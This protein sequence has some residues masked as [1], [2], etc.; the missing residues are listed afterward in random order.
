MTKLAIKRPVTICMLVI[1][2]LMLGMVSYNS[3]EQAYMP[4]VDLPVAMVMT[5]Y[6]GA[7]PEEV[8]KLVTEPIES[9]LATMTG[10]DTLTS[11]SSSG[12]SM[13]AVTFV[14]GTDLDEA[15]NDMRDKLE[16]VTRQLPDDADD[17]S[18]MKMDMDSSS[19]QI[20]IT[21]DKMD[22]ASLYD[23]VDENLTYEFERIEGV[24]SVSLNGGVDK[25]IQVVIDPEKISQYGLTISSISQALAAENQD[26]SAGELKQGSQDITLRVAGSFDNI[27]DIKNIYLTTTGGN[28]LLLK[29]VATS[30]EEV[31]LDQERISIIN[32]TEGVM[33]ETTLASDAN[34]VD[35]SHDILDRISE[36]EEKYPDL[37]F[38]M[39]SSTSDYIENSLN[40]VVET[41]FQAAIIAVLI[42]LFFLQN[43]KSAAVIGVSIPTSIMATFGVMKLLGMTMNIVSMGGIV[44][45]IG[46]LVDN[47]VVVLENIYNYRARG[48]SAAEASEKG[49]AEVA[50]AVMASTLTTVAVFAPMLFI[51]G[52]MG[53]MLKD[54]A[55]TICV[56]LAAS[57]FVSITFVPTAC[58]VLMTGED[59]ERK[60][61]KKHTVFNT[62]GDAINGVLSRLDFAYSRLIALCLRHRIITIVVVV[63]IFI[64]S[65][66]SSGMLGM[67]LMG[68]SDEGTLSVSARIPDGYGY[69]YSY[70]ILDEIM[71]AV[72]DIPETKTSYAM[73]GGSN[74]RLEINLVSSDDRQRSTDDIADEIKNEIKNIAG[75]EITVSSGSMAM[76]SMG[77]RGFSLKI[78]GEDTDTLRQICDDLI[79]EFETIDG[80]YDL[81]SSMDEAS[82]QTDIVVDRAKAASYGISSSQIASQVYTYNSGTVG[83]TLKVDGTETDIR[84]MYPDERVEYVKDLYSMTVTTNSGT[85][86]P[87]TE[88]AEIKTSDVPT[89]ISRENQ[90]RY[91]TITGSIENT[92]TST[93]TALITEKLNNY[94]FPDNYS[95][96]F[97][98]MQEYMDEAFGQLFIVLVVA[99]ILVFLIM[100][101]QFE[102]LIQP[103]I[104]M[105]SMPIAITGGMLGL[106]VT[107]L[108]ITAYAFMGFIMLVGMVVNNAIVLVDYA[109]QRRL[110]HGMECDEALIDA[111]RSRLR[112]ILMTTL[113]TVFGMVPMALALSE[114]M[115]TQQSMGVVIIFGL[116][117]S[118]LVT[119]IFIPVVYSLVNS[120]TRK[121]KRITAKFSPY[122]GAE[123]DKYSLAL[124]EY[125][126]NQN[127]HHI[128]G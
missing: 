81:E 67:D 90:Q 6:Q 70:E 124:K 75:A 26:S 69:E 19:F 45:G 18:I 44:I 50:M 60:S 27:E 101:S 80:A 100:A 73:V 74:V 127:N 21:S 118:T 57:Y 10:V 4:T 112:P 15:V 59:R 35:L 106:L 16:R 23:Y 110:L 43:W 115:E 126:K 65:L 99:I 98:G 25:E 7:G 52:T 28:G 97:G 83:T 48:F 3:L 22:I 71:N 78:I 37:H 20:G 68:Q 96:D 113:T 11:R 85:E 40:N 108:S 39:L 56:A 104:V 24:A 63:A 95:Y 46:M 12:S 91:V 89:T 41:A 66:S 17:P 36:L 62:I 120:I 128:S 86:I 122:I 88:F 58:T 29:D 42:L 30:I 125:R 72:G 49:T 93:Q 77:G 8:E 114:G 31:E 102:S 53:Q 111:G 92:D 79:A 82:V 105:F 9:Q 32:G 107:G 109:N 84:V 119:L 117:L 103:V 76:G 121:I 116:S 13:V 47:S 123:D 33:V 64:A 34:I 54:L 51:S 87:L 5:T 55:L 2:I 94:V 38:T 61:P 14:D 1:A